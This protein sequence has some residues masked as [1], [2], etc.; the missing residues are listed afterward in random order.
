MAQS[1]CFALPP[2]KLG[3]PSPKR[4][5][6]SLKFNRQ[7]TQDC[8]YTSGCCEPKHEPVSDCID[9]RDD[10]YE[11]QDENASPNC[12]FTQSKYSP[13]ILSESEQTDKTEQPSVMGLPNCGNTCYVNSILQV[14]R[15]TPKFI[16]HIN[17]IVS[18]Q[19]FLTKVNNFFTHISF[20]CLMKYFS[21]MIT[22]LIFFLNL[23]LAI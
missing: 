22:R 19:N 12:S 9:E 18:Y 8:V 1:T 14:L 3:S 7:L 4:L 10:Y 11:V 21:E 23:K 2:E 16:N 13:E 20:F 15:Y 5:R 6:L 17:S